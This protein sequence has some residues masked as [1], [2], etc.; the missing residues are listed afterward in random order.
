MQERDESKSD[1]L[2]HL[3]T[4]PEDVQL[5]IF[6]SIDRN[7]KRCLGTTSK[8]LYSFWSRH[9]ADDIIRNIAHR[10]LDYL[11][12]R[13]EE[14]RSA[15]AWHT[16]TYTIFDFFNLS[17]ITTRKVTQT[18]QSAFVSKCKMQIN[19]YI[20]S[21]LETISAEHLLEKLLISMVTSNHV[22][23]YTGPLNIRSH[24]FMNNCA[25][26]KNDAFPFGELDTMIRR[27]T[28]EIL[29]SL[30]ARNY[31]NKDYLIEICQ[32]ILHVPEMEK[33]DADTLLTIK[34]SDKQSK[35]LE[36]TLFYQFFGHFDFNEFC[37]PKD[38]ETIE[39]TQ[40]G[41]RRIE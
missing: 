29:K 6:E 2:S 40:L 5:P 3:E 39:Y 10:N 20:N 7:S 24:A 14:V 8:A 25:P 32:R 13:K 1:E 4:L 35:T 16:N 27:I 38:S 18:Q 31:K 34:Y 22:R 9:Y 12:N 30:E 23:N 21:D 37:R 15:I 19:S 41:F 28:T 33:A 11:K 17:K 26:T 36:Y